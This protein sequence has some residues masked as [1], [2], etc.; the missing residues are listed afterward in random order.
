MPAQL[1]SGIHLD[2]GPQ[3][4][5][6]VG[7]AVHL[8][9]IVVAT[10]RRVATS[11]RAPWVASDG[12][13]KTL[14]S[15]F[16][17]ANNESTGA[18]VPW[19]VGAPRN[20]T[21][22]SPWGIAAAKNNRAHGS[23]GRFTGRALSEHVAPWQVS[24]AVDD[25]ARAPWDRFTGVAQPENLS[26]WLVSAA[27]DHAAG[28][29]WGGPMVIATQVEAAQFPASVG[30]ATTRWVPWTK[31]SR[32]LAP[33]VGVTIPPDDGVPEALIVVP[34]RSVYMQVNASSLR[35]VVGDINLP[36]Y[37]MS[38]SLDRDSWVWTFNASMPADVLPLVERP[39]GADPVELEVSINGLPFRLLAERVSRDRTFAKAAITVT[40]RGKQMLLDDPYVPAMNFANIADRTVQQI[41]GDVLTVNAVPM[42][43]TVNFGLE[44]WL[45]PANTWSFRGSYM[46]ALN[47][48]AAAGGGYLQPHATE[49][50][51]VLLPQYPV[52]PWKWATD[53]D[54]DYELPSAP[55]T[56][57]G[58]EWID[59]PV[60]DR[61]YV[62]GTSRGIV[63]R[64][65]RGGTAGGLVAQGVAHSLITVAAAA[66]QRGIP[67]LSDTGRQAI[68]SLRLPVLDETGVI[69]PG[70]FVRYV[71]GAT[72]RIGLVRSVGLDVAMPQIWQTIQ[73]ETHE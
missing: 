9:P 73:L 50:S 37:R 53:V 45:V 8:E 31:F 24:A 2:Y 25:A 27:S 44:D 49:Q 6:Q 65:T 29:P 30:I 23:W 1:G 19:A 36:V 35:K 56:R 22:R 57:E 38:M 46:G 11:A 48:I 59:K 63:G 13:E 28:L 47:D 16:V 71:D 12:A 41:I 5:R 68:V 42:D 60:Y 66:R 69:V 34:V 72:T 54:P 21:E 33:S 3:G 32:T 15:G 58:I 64:V 39:F 70:K 52:V 10:S 67:I 14:R 26:A 4:A 55:V 40:G 18:A 20:S 62:S 17:R 7:S 43:W 61:V 51:M